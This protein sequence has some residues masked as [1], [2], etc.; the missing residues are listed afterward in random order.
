MAAYT[1]SSQY[2]EYLSGVK[3]TDRQI[4][5]HELH[6]KRPC[7]MKF[8]AT[9]DEAFE[10]YKN[11]EEESHFLFFTSLKDNPCTIIERSDK[12]PYFKLWILDN[13]IYILYEL[14]NLDEV[15]SR[16]I[17]AFKITIKCFKKNGKFKKSFKK[18]KIK[19]KK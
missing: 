18:E 1:M 11:E 4:R 15:K 10:A 5:T 8:F 16:F 7:V 12:N 3:R 2:H 14:K 9:S 19:K 17:E 6:N 13:G